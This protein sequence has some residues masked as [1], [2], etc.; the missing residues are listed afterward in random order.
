VYALDVVDHQPYLY[1]QSIRQQPK[2]IMCLD[3]G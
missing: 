2:L 3:L 1:I